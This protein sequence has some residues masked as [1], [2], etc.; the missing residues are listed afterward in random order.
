MNVRELLASFAT[1]KILVIGDTIID[2]ETLCERI[3]DD[4]N[5]VPTY[6]TILDRRARSETY[7]FGGAALVVR[8]LLELGAKVDFITA[9]GYGIGA[10]QFETWTHPNLTKHAIKVAKPQTTKHRFWCDGKKV[11]QVD[12]VDNTP[13]AMTHCFLYEKPDAI[14]VAD[15]RHGLIDEPNARY[16]V[17]HASY[18]NIPIY[19]ASQV[20][21]SESNHHWYEGPNTIYVANHQEALSCARLT[22]KCLVATW[23]EFG[24]SLM[25]SGDMKEFVKGIPVNVVDTCGAGDAFLAAYSLS[26]GIQTANLWAALSCAVHGANPPTQSQL[27]EWCEQHGA[28]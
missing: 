1:K 18:H 17:S 8:N 16:L 11:M 21:Q 9:T 2:I 28:D 19:V 25:D 22:S 14:V 23:G 20:S 10:L 24:A 4:E 12:T 15:Y 5:G 7:S 13:H 3:K 27:L 26:G 6:R